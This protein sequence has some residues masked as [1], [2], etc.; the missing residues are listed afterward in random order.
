MIK[1]I[2]FDLDGT[3]ID[4][5]DD[6]TAAVN[7]ML[8]A[9]G[10][11]AV[12]RAEV[13]AMVGKGARNLV[14]QALPG[15]SAGEIDQGLELF[16]RYN[17]EHIADRTVAYA[18]VRETLAALAER[19]LTMTVISNKHERLCRRILSC[20]GLDGWFAGVYG[21]DSLPAMKPSPQPL[22]HVMDRFGRTPEQTVIVG[23]SINDVAAGRGAGVVTVGCGYGYG[24]AA[25]LADADYRIAAFTELLRLPLFD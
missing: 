17:E 8:A 5:L 24:T 12:G 7:Q 4:S 11:P 20:L 15:A 1:L 3:L 14:E 13:R 23:D 6:L 22:L 21:A 9:F 10:R 2:I 19:G 25:E 18:G 16:L